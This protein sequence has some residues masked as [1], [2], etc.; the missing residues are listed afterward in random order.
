MTLKLFK[1]TNFI[2]IALVIIISHLACKKD[3][4][5]DCTVNPPVDSLRWASLGGFPDEFSGNGIYTENFLLGIESDVFAISRTGSVWRYNAGAKSWLHISSFPEDIGAAPVTF[6]VSGMGYCMGRGHCWQFNPAINQWIRKKDPPS[7]SLGAPLVIGDKAYLRTRDSNH[8]FAY[9]PATDVYTQ[10]S[11]P[12]DFGNN[13]D[14]LGYFV[15]NDQGYYV[16][17]YGG[18]WQYD[19]S[20][21]KWQQRASFKGV[22]PVYRAYP[23]VG[24]SLNHRGYL[25]NPNGVARRLWQYDASLNQ[26]TITNDDY[27]GDGVNNV[28]VVSLDSIAYIGLG[29][30]DEFEATDFWSYS[31]YK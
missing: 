2:I 1:E 13:L 14:L 9:D 22:D 20:L 11:D 3:A 28:Q 12:P 17:G 18:C 8:L 23:G 24:F 7:V 15:I 6:S 21:D 4:C 25:L 10:Q 27:Q 19:A 16:S 29:R 31:S 5:E 26:W 30:I